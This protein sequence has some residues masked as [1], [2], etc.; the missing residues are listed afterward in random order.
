MRNVAAFARPTP[1]RIEA[2][3]HQHQRRVF[4]PSLSQFS[5]KGWAW[6]SQ[7]KTHGLVD[8]AANRHRAFNCDALLLRI[9]GPLTPRRSAESTLPGHEGV[10][11]ASI[12]GLA[13]INLADGNTVYYSWQDRMS[14]SALCRTRAINT[15][16]V[17]MM[18]DSSIFITVNFTSTLPD[19]PPRQMSWVRRRDVTRWFG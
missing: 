1:S 13:C 11:L 4:N 19:A 6:I 12:V 18:P 8:A 3:H 15:H 9:Q 2:R 7:G 14:V 16:P 5:P 10:L 17:D